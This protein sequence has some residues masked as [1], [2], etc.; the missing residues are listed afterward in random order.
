MH[1]PASRCRGRQRSLEQ[2]RWRKQR[3]NNAI[4]QTIALSLA[5]S[6]DGARQS[7]DAVVTGQ[8]PCPARPFTSLGVWSV[9]SP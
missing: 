3:L 6:V 9:I 2:R 4:L 5:G 8:T 1:R 7:V